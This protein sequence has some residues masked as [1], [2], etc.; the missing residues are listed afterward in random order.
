MAQYLVWIDGV[1]NRQ[2]VAQHQGEQG[3]YK[4]RQ[5]GHQ[6]HSQVECFAQ[7][8][9]RHLAC[10]RS[11]ITICQNDVCVSQIRKPVRENSPSCCPN[12]RVSL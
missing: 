9:G 1:R 8:S 11:P 4:Q 6:L 3:L 5:H 7:C 2:R 10:R 12:R